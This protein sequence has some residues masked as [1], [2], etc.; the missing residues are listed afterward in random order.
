MFS[1]EKMDPSQL[2]RFL[3]K[4]P[5]KS[6]RAHFK[7]FKQQDTEEILAFIFDEL[8]SNFI[9]TLDLVQGKTMV[10]NEGLSCHQI[11]DNEDFFAIFQL[12]VAN[13]VQSSLDLF[14]TLEHLS[15]DN[16]FSVTTRLRQF[17]IIQLKQFV[18]F[19]GTVTEDRHQCC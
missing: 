3:K 7:I 8:C 5:G 2:L 19:Q 10:T 13:I 14:L 15:G 9:L 6:G 16:F 11:I 4:L 17:L 12:L 18:N 1:F